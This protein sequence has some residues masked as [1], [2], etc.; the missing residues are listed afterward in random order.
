MA[1]S[2]AGKS[3]EDEDVCVTW[4]LRDGVFRTRMRAGRGV[5]RDG[6]LR[7]LMCAWRGCCGTYKSTTKPLKFNNN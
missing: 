5:L 7:P 6:V 3:D 4:V 2:V 1:I